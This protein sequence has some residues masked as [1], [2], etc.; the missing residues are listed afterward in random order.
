M[1]GSIHE[2]VLVNEVIDA[3]SIKAD[4]CYLDGTFGRGGHS[5]AILNALGSAGRLLAVDKDQ[6]AIDFARTNFDQD[7]RLNAYKSSFA[8]LDDLLGSILK[9]DR[10]DGALFDLGVSS[11]QLDQPERGFSFRHSGPLD[12]RMDQDARETAASWLASAELYELKKVFR[13]YGEERFAGRIANKI[14]ELREEHPFET[15]DQLADLISKIVPTREKGKHPATRV[16]Q[17]IRI[18]VNRELEE[19]QL[20]LPAVLNWIKPGGRLVVISFHSLEDRIVKRFM[21]DQAKGDDFPIDLAVTSDMLNPRI[22][23]ISKAV[24]PGDEEV[25]RNPRS[26]SAVMRAAQK[27]EQHS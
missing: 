15:T 9:D 17:A 7:A 16:F 5:Q 23:L 6:Q 21:R 11:P 8:N 12:M 25:G 1:T 26:R 20:M 2:P 19:L 13:Q 18:R 24:R 27:L 10:L 14:V 22:K 3:L 4:G